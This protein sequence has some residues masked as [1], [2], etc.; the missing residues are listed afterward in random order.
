[1]EKHFI[2]FENGKVEAFKFFTADALPHIQRGS[3]RI[4]TSSSF[5]EAEKG[6]STGRGD[7]GEM[8]HRW[9]IAEEQVITGEHPFLKPFIER[10]IAK[11]G[12]PPIPPNEFKMIMS[13]DCVIIEHTECRMLCL[14]RQ[15]DDEIASRMWKE[16]GAEYYYRINDLEK[17]VACLSGHPDLETGEIGFVTYDKTDDGAQYE[18]DPF[19]KAARFSWQQEIRLVFPAPQPVQPLDVVIPEILELIEIHQ[20]PAIGS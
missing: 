5:R 2:S 15:I 8:V 20:N 17:Y 16:F 6:E 9:E 19:T 3:V 11:F 4:N 1:M 12:P 14:S 7:P 13:K 10:S 18:P